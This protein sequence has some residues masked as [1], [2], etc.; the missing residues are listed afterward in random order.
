[1]LATRPKAAKVMFI[2]PVRVVSRNAAIRNFARMSVLGARPFVEQSR[3][4]V[5]PL[6]ADLPDGN[7]T[8][9]WSIVSGR[10]PPGGRRDRVRRRRG[11]GKPDGGARDA[12]YRD[13]AAAAMRGTFFLGVLAA[14]GAAFFAL[15]VLRSHAPAPDVMRRHTLLL[16]SSFLIAFVARTR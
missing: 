1:M 3:T 5:V 11:G 10:R 13:L 14:V 4:L 9:R 8:V 2:D 16:G 7:Y 15:V 6:K 12:L